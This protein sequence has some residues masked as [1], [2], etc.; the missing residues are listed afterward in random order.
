MTSRT[1]SRSTSRVKKAIKKAN[2]GVSKKKIRSNPQPNISHNLFLWL[3]SQL[4]TPL[5]LGLLFLLKTLS[6]FQVTLRRLL[7]SPF[8]ISLSP[9]QLHQQARKRRLLNQALKNLSHHLPSKRLTQFRRS[10]AST[11]TR[12]KKLLKK[13][14][15]HLV[16]PPLP[17][18]P[19]VLSNLP[20]FSLLAFPSINPP[21][22]DFSQIFQTLIKSLQKLPRL[23]I[24]FKPLRLPRFQFRL[25]PHHHFRL[26]LPPF[27]Q[28]KL[29]L[30]LSRLS[31]I[32][33]TTRSSLPRL[34]F[35]LQPLNTPSF[36]KP[37]EVELTRHRRLHPL[38]TT[39]VVAAGIATGSGYYFYQQIIKDLPDPT[40]LATDTPYLSTKIYDR[41]GKLLFKF[42]QNENRS[43]VSLD[44][45]PLHL[46]Q[47]TIAIE[48][49]DFYQHFGLSM[50]GIMR[51]L[52]VNSSG[53]HLQG[54]STITQQL[55]KNTLLTPERTLERKIKEALLSVLTEFYFS[56]NEILAMYFNQVPYGGSAYGVQ[57]ASR[58]YFDKNVEDLT[59]AQSAYIAGLPAA[60]TF[61]SPYGN[62]PEMAI[63]RQQEVLRRMVED[64]Y[65]SPE[66]A[67]DASQEK[68]ALIPQKSII[69]AP[70]FVMY[71]KDYLSR[72]YSP[73]LVEHGGLEVTTS[74]DLDLQQLVQQIV[75]TEVSK[76]N[77]LNVGNG[78]ALVTNPSTGEILAMV[79]ST[80]YFDTAHD[81]QV[82][83]TLA[84]R[85]PG[86]S[87]KPINYAVALENGFTPASIVD[88]QRVC[89]QIKGQEPYCPQNYDGSFHG[90]VTLRKAL[91]NSYNI[92]AVKILNQVGVSQMIQKGQ[93][94][95]ITTWNDTNR[96]G[97]SLTLGGGEVTM[98]DL[99]TVYGVFANQGNRIDTNPILEIKDSSGRILE[100]NCYKS[101]Y[102][103][104]A[105]PCSSPQVLDPRVA[106]QIT[107]ILSDNQARADA[108]GSNSVLHIPNQQVA[109]KT[110][111]TNS[112]R[113]NW[114]IG[115]TSDLLVA[116]WVGNNNN[117]PMSYIASGITGAS[118]IWNQI[119]L[120]LLNQK[121]P[122]TF[123]PPINLTKVNICTF[124]GTL[125]CNGCPSTEEYFI[126]GT[127]P[128]SQCSQEQIARFSN[129][130]PISAAN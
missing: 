85:Q 69:H 20:S 120:T 9:H 105:N 44:Q 107:H 82:N 79:G 110:G 115:Y 89:F 55:V 17:K 102:L 31:P 121:E 50:R 87:I 68:L 11:H 10:L 21:R 65:I 112:L 19:S 95:G 73:Q 16:L 125:A 29:H 46:Q 39:F 67:Q 93:A 130:N 83:V 90:R 38:V 63:Q 116:A 7:S 96:F 43:L 49:Q 26:N 27:P 3:F 52:K 75:T 111:T 12:S 53:G 51:A 40:R 42:Y 106:F 8:L 103:T 94:M 71:V 34:S 48:D 4:G 41:S 119:M 32:I 81:G 113:D 23:H 70:H 104:S 2:K 1:G 74:L 101:H 77:R 123:N 76:L 47:A 78:A 14:P 35:L 56:K 62:Q 6:H 64:G 98:L 37:L 13:L 129:P 60:P 5:T 117:T 22:F 72:K 127:E 108:F 36:L 86:S 84:H 88:D 66:L 114:T 59:L 122:H 30:L 18:V 99:A 54:G 124:T 100:T 92:P 45:I 58:M 61:Y 97:L 109:V 33:S 91:A 24:H 118:P 126:P 80:N 25:R 128:R 57:E 28:F 15:T